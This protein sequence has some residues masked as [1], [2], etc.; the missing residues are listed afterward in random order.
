MGLIFKGIIDS[1][2]Y[3]FLPLPRMPSPLG[4]HSPALSTS[5][6]LSEQGIFSAAASPRAFGRLYHFRLP[7]GEH[8]KAVSPSNPPFVCIQRKRFTSHI[9][10]TLHLYQC[11]GG[12]SCRSFNSALPPLKPEVVQSSKSPTA[13]FYQ[14][15]K[16]T[17]IGSLGVSL[18]ITPICLIVEQLLKLGRS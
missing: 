1:F 8:G 13:S 6:L 14:M 18:V 9:S 3:S 5:S 12:F 2:E 15:Q 16:Q 11:R 17:L 4:G 7:V 10:L